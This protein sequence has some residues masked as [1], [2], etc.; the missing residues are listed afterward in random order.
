MT[1]PTIELVRVAGTH[2]EVGLQLGE[3]GREQ[4][5]RTVETS[6]DEL[7]SG[8]SKAD[9][10][11]LADEYRTFS[12][13]RLPWLLEELDACA[14]GAGVDPLEFFAV[15]MEEIWYEPYGPRT[16]GRCSDLVAGPSATSDGH[17]LV[18]HNNDLR[19]EAEQDITALEISV[20]GDPVFFQLGGIPWLSVG[21][22]AAGLSLTGNELAP[23]DER[24]G[25][26]RSHQ[27]LEM[28]R[29]SSLDE[30]VGM[31]LR[32]D[33]ASSY[34]NVLTSFDGGVA[35][36]EG[37]ATDAEVT[38]LDDRA[39]LAHTNNYVCD[40]ML[41][42]E[43]DT[44]YAPLSQVRYERARE[45][46]AVQPPVSLTMDRLRELLSDHQ[47][48]PQ[49]LC[50]HPEFGTPTSKTVF[51]CVADVTYGRVRY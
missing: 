48:R 42:Y 2:R 26:S 22:N 12:A 17:L 10:L 14:E 34:N 1:P 41:P 20:P 5:R 36:V 24:V 3:A 11:A 33:R 37:S 16:D 15:S 32:T 30:M 19:P 6:W 13:P 9:Q 23:N 29:A 50:K 51:W 46:L 44:E 35:N 27:V 45:L 31:A 38:G 43:G 21:W 49:S 40:R 8:R 25:I 39:H 47:T 4:I 18:A 7:P 28:M